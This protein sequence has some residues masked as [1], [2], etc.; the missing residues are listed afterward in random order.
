MP[1]PSM[2]Q[3]IA[4]IRAAVDA[5]QQDEE[6]LTRLVREF[7]AHKEYRVLVSIVRSPSSCRLEIIPMEK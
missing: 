7:N 4:A 6:E 1:E 5:E 3:E 2:S